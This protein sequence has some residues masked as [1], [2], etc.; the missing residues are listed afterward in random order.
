MRK[1]FLATPGWM[2]DLSLWETAKGLQAATAAIHSRGNIRQE[3]GV[4]F[5]KAKGASAERAGASESIPLGFRMARPSWI[6]AIACSGWMQRMRQRIN[7]WLL[8][9]SNTVGAGCRPPRPKWTRQPGK[10]G[11]A[12]P[13]GKTM[14]N[15]LISYSADSWDQGVYEIET[16][17]VAREYTE[18]SISERYRDLSDEAVNELKGFPSNICC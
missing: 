6:S 2:T 5:G 10:S 17:R 9:I 3:L 14:Y 4:P 8:T 15:L 1:L 18:E 13:Q 16:A 11:V 7:K 12:S